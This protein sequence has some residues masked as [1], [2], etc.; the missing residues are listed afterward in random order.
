MRGSPY[1]QRQ[2]RAGYQLRREAGAA[3]EDTGDLVVAKEEAELPEYE[4]PRTVRVQGI[5]AA[6]GGTRLRPRA[7]K[8]VAEQ[9]IPIT[10]MDVAAHCPELPREQVRARA[11]F[12]GPQPRYRPMRRVR[13]RI[14]PR[15]AQALSGSFN[16]A[17]PHRFSPLPFKGRGEPYG[18]TGGG[19]VLIA[20]PPG[21]GILTSMTSSPGDWRS[22]GSLVPAAGM[23]NDDR[24]RGTRAGLRFHR[25]RR[26]PLETRARRTSAI[27]G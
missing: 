10:V 16:T 20:G 1:R 22:G 12:L 24:P 26:P 14:R 18:G 7:M 25:A 13:E 6:A 19:P 15:A 3:H 9:R 17:V 2:S 5:N 21:G 8:A 23:R 27:A 4:T 11:P